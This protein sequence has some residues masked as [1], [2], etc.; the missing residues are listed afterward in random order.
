MSGLKKPVSF[1]IPCRNEQE[2]L[3]RVLTKINKLC[4]DD[5]RDRQTEVIVCDNGSTDRSA[6]IA[7]E[8]GTKVVHCERKGYGAALLCGIEEAG[9]EVVVFADA[10][11]TYDFLETPKLVEELEKGFDLVIGSRLQGEIH[12]GAMPFLHRYLGTPVLNF[13][14]NLLYARDRTKIS[15]CNSG[16]RCFLRSSFL[17]WGVKSEGMEF[18]SEM[19]VKA[20]KSK[21]RISHVP[22]SLYPDYA[23]RAPHLE[24]WR[25]GMRHLLQIFLDS[26]EFF[27]FA[28]CGLFAISWLII[29]LGLFFGPVRIGFATVLGLHSMMFG[30]LGSLFG[31]IIWAVGL[32]LVVRIDTSIKAYRWLIEL[33]EDKLF[34]CSVILTL[35]SVALF[36]V[37]VIHWGIRGFHDIYIEKQTLA[38]VTFAANSMV[39]VSNMVT[40]HLLKRP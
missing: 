39:F 34:W 21:A 28:G 22:V 12:K 32:F 31:I 9:Y 17:S 13:F 26:P 30:L 19:L 25:D 40:A 6:E 24:R 29:L 35:I 20:L 38:I 7:R 3:G 11:N 18:A 5:F 16:F 36:L 23:E 37:V 33:P 8:H 14:L 2:T 15:D 10:D 1:V 27:F 4:D